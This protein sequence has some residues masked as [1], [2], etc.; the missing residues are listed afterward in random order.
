MFKAGTVK[1]LEALGL[2]EKLP[3]E[4]YQEVL[5]VVT[6]LDDT[7][8]AERDVEFDDGGYVCVALNQED[9]DYFD[10]NCVALE[11]LAL[12]SVDI[13]RSKKEVYLNVFFLVN[14][15]ESGVSLFVP[16]LIAP[17]RFFKETSAATVH[18]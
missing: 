3:E 9:I 10:K 4:I 11:S 5:R 18:R 6:Y 7:F 16:I 12:E 8:G 13:V 14:E 17:D 15:Y 1:E 2:E